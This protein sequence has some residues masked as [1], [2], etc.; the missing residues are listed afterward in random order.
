M[1]SINACGLPFFAENP[2]LFEEVIEADLI[3][4]RRHTGAA[5]VGGVGERTEHRMIRALLLTVVVQ[6]AVLQLDAAVGLARDVGVVRDHEDGVAGLVQLAKNFH[7]DGFVGLVEIAGGLV[8]EDQLGLIYQGAGDGDAL[9]FAAGKL[10]RQMR[11]AIAEA[12]ATKGFGSLRFVGDAVEVLREHHVFY[13]GE[14][15]D[16]MK[17]LEDEADFFGAVA[18][19]LRFG[20]FC[21]IGAIDDYSAGGKGVKAAEDVDEGGFAGA[22]RAHQ[23][24]PFAGFDGE[25]ERVDGAEGAVLLGKGF[26]LDLGGHCVVH[27][28]RRTAAGRMLARR[29]NG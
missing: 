4:G 18:D 12:D 11:E 21:E 6:A 16:E 14:I 9:L 25:R 1:Q 13:G 27:S 28:P 19:E 20:E 29:R 2:D 22:G 7:H 15:W 24:D 8:G 23:G 26:D 17:L 5:A 10:R 3:V